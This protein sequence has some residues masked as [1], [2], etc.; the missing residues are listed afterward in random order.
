[1][2]ILEQH[3]TL[4]SDTVSQN[5]RLVAG[6]GQGHTEAGQSGIDGGVLDDVPSLIARKINPRFA[7]RLKNRLNRL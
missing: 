3:A 2:T 4:E 1:M 6:K 5:S 7:S